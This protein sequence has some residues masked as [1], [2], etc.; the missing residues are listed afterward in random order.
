MLVSSV[1]WCVIKAGVITP[2]FSL[3]NWDI[4]DGAEC[5]TLPGTLVI[6]NLKVAGVCPRRPC[7]SH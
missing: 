5:E 6:V 4:S 2:C 7:P 1:Y 3:L